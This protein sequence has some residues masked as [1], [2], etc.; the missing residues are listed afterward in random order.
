MDDI[1]LVAKLDND[2]TLYVSPVYENTYNEFIEDNAL[3]GV[4]GY[5]ITRERFN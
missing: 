5:F 1:T 4:G 3:G 2:T